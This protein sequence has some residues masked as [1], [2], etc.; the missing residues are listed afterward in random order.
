MPFRLL[1]SAATRSAASSLT[2][3][4]QRRS[5]ERVRMSCRGMVGA[6]AAQRAV[7]AERAGAD[8]FEP[9]VGG[10]RHN[11]AIEVDEAGLLLDAVRIVTGGAGGL[12]ID[13]MEPVSSILAEGIGGFEAL[14]GQDAVAA[15]AFV[16]KRV[17]SNVLRCVIGED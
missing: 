8:E 14:V 7:T 5:G 13:D 3:A 2:A 6:V 11:V 16:A 1:T 4:T 12:L 10:R 9:A 17:G 15:V